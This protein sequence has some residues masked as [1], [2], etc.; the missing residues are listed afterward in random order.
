[1]K[2]IFKAGAVHVVRH[3]RVQYEEQVKNFS[4]QRLKENY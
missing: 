4:V 1:V 3:L 2:A